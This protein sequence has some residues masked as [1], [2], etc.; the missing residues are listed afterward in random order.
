MLSGR[1]AV[2]PVLLGAGENLF[3]G[4]ELRALGYRC[5][6]RVATGNATHLVLARHPHSG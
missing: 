3:A 4:I 2:A 5:V 1:P 6:K